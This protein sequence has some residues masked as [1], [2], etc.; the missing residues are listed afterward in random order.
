MGHGDLA[1]LVR[2]G[3]GEGFDTQASVAPDEA[4]PDQ[5]D[6]SLK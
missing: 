4:L 1:T 6:D 2:F 5:P 3:V